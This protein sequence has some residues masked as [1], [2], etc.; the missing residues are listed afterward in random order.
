MSGHV[1]SHKNHSTRL[2]RVLVKGILLIATLSGVGLAL[3]YGVGAD[4]LDKNWI[5]VSIRGH[6]LVGMLVFVG[7]GALFTSVGLPRQVIS[8]L[9]G[10]AWGVALGFVWAL[11]ATVLGGLLAF[12]WARLMGR[13]FIRDRFGERVGRVDDFL[14]TNSF[15]MVLLVRLFPVVANILTNVAAGVTS[16]RPVPYVFG[17]LL[18]YAPQTFIFALLGSGITV[19]P[20]VRI[21]LAAVLYVLATW[22][23]YALYRRY[24]PSRVLDMDKESASS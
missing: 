2:L 7:A 11:T 9:A 15:T 1:T 14:K 19:A 23:G 12:Y 5:D 17:S 22:L 13:R 8:F 21:T 20:A 10:Y 16:I 4:L 6:G 24:K 3:H 18:G